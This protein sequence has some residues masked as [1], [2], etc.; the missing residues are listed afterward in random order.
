MFVEWINEYA[1]ENEEN[2]SVTEVRFLVNS[3]ELVL[4]KEQGLVTIDEE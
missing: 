2:D 3:E 1:R 4:T